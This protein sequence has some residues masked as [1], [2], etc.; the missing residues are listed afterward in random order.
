MGRRVP[1]IRDEETHLEEDRWIVYLSKLLSF[2]G[3]C[4]LQTRTYRAKAERRAARGND[5][6]G[7]M[8]VAGDKQGFIYIIICLFSRRPWAF[9][10]SA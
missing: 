10:T 9:S 8:I 7:I 4:G 1:S 6:S 2:S 3:I 5:S